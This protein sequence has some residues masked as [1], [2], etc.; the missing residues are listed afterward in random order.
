MKVAFRVDA[1]NQIGTGHLMRCLTL[2]NALKQHGA[3]TRF[4]SRHMPE[5]FRDMLATNGHEFTLLESSPVEVIADDLSHSHWLGTSQLDDALDSIRA[6]A[7][8]SL[9][10]L[11]VDHYALD[12]RW[13]KSLRQ[14]AKSI[15]V[16]D[17]LADRMHD[18]DL[19]LDQNLGRLA[20][21][22]ADMVP[23]HC[24]VLT[25]PRYALL[26]PEF[27]AL[28]EY[29][30]QRRKN[31]SLKHILISMGGVDQ[32]N[33]TGQVLEALKLCSLPPECRITVVMG[34]QAPGLLRV[35]EIAGTMPWPTMVRVDIEDMAQVMADS[36]LAIGAA[37]TT[38]WER[39]CLGL[40][41]LLV[42]LADNQKE[43]A[44]HMIKEGVAQA[45][46]VDAT[47]ANTL[48]QYL[49]EYLTHP[50]LLISVSKKASSVTEGDGCRQVVRVMEY[51][52]NS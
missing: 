32:P 40:P 38:S 8:S 30:L 5:H 10:W 46:R 44:S 19:L 20:D 45:F 29:S 36:D 7:D 25:G 22:Y 34:G 14:V 13:E 49:R 52:K 50:D 6:L 24:V 9:D 23:K 26:R 18:C 47:L 15:L 4:V 28:R 3:Y 43:A 21:G 39:C 11:V 12:M 31:A 41:A 42:V 33:A 35:R 2:A 1:S 17:D 51:S 37:G 27:A 16:I 48:G